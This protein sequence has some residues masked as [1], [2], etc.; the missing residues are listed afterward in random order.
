MQSLELILDAASDREV[1]RQWAA[2]AEAGLPSL[3][4]H[5]GESNRP[6]VTV[7]AREL[8]PAE[9][10]DRLHGLVGLLPMP[11]R[12]GSPLL[13]RHRRGFVLARQVVVTRELLGLHARA[14]LLLGPGG[15]PLT[16]PDAWTPHVT[17]AR[18][19]GLDQLPLAL[20]AAGTSPLDA[21]AT[22]L[23]RWDSE[24]A[25]VWMLGAR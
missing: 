15:S 9:R 6:H 13:F 24:V 21:T 23:R 5:R 18:G 4:S 11:L 12:I 22:H 19:L 2:L 14:Q 25:R 1:R 10:D 3:A 8:V 16:R 20:E 17:L 7:D